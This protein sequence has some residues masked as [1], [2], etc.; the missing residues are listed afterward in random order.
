MDTTLSPLQLRKVEYA[1]SDYRSALMLLR[2]HVA[3]DWSRGYI[4]RVLAE[5]N[6]P[7]NAHTIISSR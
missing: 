4:D 6:Q 5:H 3:D 7:D 2:K 1:L